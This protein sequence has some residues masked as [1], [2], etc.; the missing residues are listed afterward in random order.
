MTCDAHS[1]RNRLLQLAPTKTQAVARPQPRSP[2]DQKKPTM[3]T[4]AHYATS[5]V[6]L[7]LPG[8]ATVRKPLALRK[9]PENPLALSVASGGSVSGV[10]A[11]RTKSQ[12]G[13][14]AAVP[15][16]VGSKRF[17]RLEGQARLDAAVPCLA[18]AL[19]LIQR[20]DGWCQGTLTDD[21][22]RCSL[23]GALQLGAKTPLETYFAREVVRRIL[24]EVD[25]TAWND[26][27]F[28]CRADV[29]RALKAA[30]K[31]CRTHVRRGG[32]QVS[33]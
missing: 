23:N 29:V 22:G 12:S 9:T 27:P 21:L 6:Q 19:S 15:E 5:A 25:F 11:R 7:N 33:R 14:V 24:H 32:W 31:I 20:R 1:F 17:V 4:N 8:I 16:E 26:H 30:L 3:T 2:M 10:G 28:R 13:Y 18:R